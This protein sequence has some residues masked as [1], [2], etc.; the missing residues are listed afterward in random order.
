MRYT[1]LLLIFML[2]T[3]VY[4]GELDYEAGRAAIKVRPQYKASL[5][6]SG[7]STG[8]S[9][10]DQHLAR[11]GVRSVKP[12]FK[13]S[14]KHSSPVDLSLILE[15][16]FPP[17]SD[18]IGICNSL[19]RNEAILWAE[20]I[21]FYHTLDV[22][23]DPYYPRMDYL[24]VMQTDAAWSIHKGQNGSEPTILAVVDTGMNW[25][26]AELAPNIWNNLGEDANGNGYTIYWTGSTWAFDPGD[27]NGVDDDSN[28]YVDDLIGWD[29]YHDLAGNQD[30]DPFDA[31]GHGTSVSCIANAR[32]DNA[33]GIASVAWNVTLM[34][35]A[36]SPDGSSIGR[37]YDAILYA[38][39]N[40][41]HVI[42]CSWGGITFS[43]ADQDLVDYVWSL[44]SIIVA[45]SG[46]SNNLIPL[47]PSSYR[48]VVAV[49]L[50][51]NAGVHSVAT[52][53]PQ[54]DVLAPM[55]SVFAISGTTYVAV[56]KYTSYA[57]P[58]ASSLIALIRSQNPTWT[59][60]QVLERLYGTCDDVYGVN[61]PAKLNLLGYGRLNAYRAVSESGAMPTA[62]LKLGI[63][64]FGIPTETDGDMAIEPSEQFSFNFI[65][66]NYALQS[67]AASLNITLSCSDPAVSIINNSFAASIASDS[68]LSVSNAFL[69]QVS[70]SAVSKYVTFYL[71]SSADVPI[72]AGASLR[73]DVLINAGGV[74][75]WEGTPN[76]P[77]MSG[78]YIRNT[79]TVAGYTCA[80]GN[81]YNINGTYFPP[82]FKG[83]SAVFLSFGAVPT[84]IRRLN[85]T[86]M[87]D[88]I[89]AYLEE[90]GRLYIEG[91]D[92]IAWD[93]ATYFPDYEP[94]LD[95]HD[96]LWPL[97]GLAS[98]DDGTD[99]VLSSIS[100]A[101]GWHT[102]GMDFTGYNLSQIRSMDK[103]TPD[104]NGVIAYS[105]PGYGTVAVQSLGAY[106]QRVVLASFALKELVDGTAPFTRSE[107]LN[108][109]MQFFLSPSLTL[110]DVQNLSITPSGNDVILDWDYPFSVDEFEIESDTD[111]YGD[112]STS[113]SPVTDTT[114]IIPSALQRFFKVTAKRAFGL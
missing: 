91:G 95:G 83:F 97:L 35:L 20:P 110:P 75:I 68:E 111:P 96:I 69:V 85:Q 44:G 11:L 63:R 104:A 92:A 56:A 13:T 17:K 112:F 66:R 4:A 42:N 23:D 98:A 88:A 7:S 71:N 94:G 39:E 32:T 19:S 30:N 70:P 24:D 51:N 62:G 74:Y 38:A 5:R 61:P 89:R 26:H 81:D 109:I 48:N 21:W 108:R 58:V 10:L 53:G 78:T 36:C 79:L 67:S 49:G 12:R 1:I 103:F 106:G 100:G 84:Y 47:Y 46:N 31:G 50:T 33:T 80:L 102:L 87:F 8:I 29:F 54:L 82:S 57:S 28:G 41:A 18:P 86:M 40:G 77:N 99:N 52:Y 64:K 55:D 59:N 15:I 16:S 37:G 22:P 14:G 114:A 6:P 105:E 113:E 90:G 34:P 101:Q 27:L 43:L 76:S 107:L 72:L 65:L 60:T 3:A 25:K 93:I 45:A 73:Y 2:S 9:S